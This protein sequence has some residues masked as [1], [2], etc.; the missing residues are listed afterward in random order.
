MEVKT[1]LSGL[2]QVFRK[3]ATGNCRRNRSRGMILEV[4]ERVSVREM[5]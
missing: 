4:M 1:Q 2:L 5:K 3:E